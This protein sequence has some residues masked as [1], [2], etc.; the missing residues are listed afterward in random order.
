[1]DLVTRSILEIRLVLEMTGRHIA[2]GRTAGGWLMLSSET[3]R[4]MELYA[5][6]SDLTL[7]ELPLS[8]LEGL[9]GGFRG[10]VVSRKL[11]KVKENPVAAC[12]WMLTLVEK[13][14][15]DLDAIELA[16]RTPEKSTWRANCRIA[17]PAS[18][19]GVCPAVDL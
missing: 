4:T 12:I 14:M 16:V 1:M 9:V 3:R 6:R 18:P 13:K 5:V 2:L 11:P 15:P 7:V 10:T 8:V 17:Y 19:P